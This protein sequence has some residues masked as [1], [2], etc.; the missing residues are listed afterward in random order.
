MSHEL[1]L[2]S[3]N[4]HSVVSSIVSQH[5]YRISS[6]TLPK[7]FAIDQSYQITAVSRQSDGTALIFTNQGIKKLPLELIPDNFTAGELKIQHIN[8]VYQLN[9]LQKIENATQFPNLEEFVKQAL[10]ELPAFK[11]LKNYLHQPFVTVELKPETKELF[12]K[13]YDS[14][15]QPSEIL[16]EILINIGAREK[17]QSEV[18]TLLTISSNQENIKEIIVSIEKHLS[19][20]TNQ[21]PSLNNLTKLIEIVRNTSNIKVAQIRDDL[22]QIIN[23]QKELLTQGQNKLTP[24]QNSLATEITNK[25]L[26]NPT[27]EA[28]KLSTFKLIE[29]A[30]GA[31][32]NSLAKISLNNNFE[33]VPK[34]TSDQ[35]EVLFK[36][37]ELLLINSSTISLSLNTDNLLKNLMPLISNLEE[38]EVPEQVRQLLKGL[39][40]KAEIPEAKNHEI[41]NK[42]AGT[43]LSKEISLDSVKTELLSSSMQAV[44]QLKQLNQLISGQELL[45]KLNPL[46]KASGEPIFLLFPNLMQNFMSSLE[47][48]YL[49]GHQNR[50]EN[51]QK[52]GTGSKQKKKFD[53]VQFRVSLPYFGGVGVDLQYNDQE[54]FMQISLEKVEITNFIKPHLECLKNILSQRANRSIFIRVQTQTTKTIA[55]EWLQ[56][57]LSSEV[58]I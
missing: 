43:S 51:Q 42:K 24:S 29:S 28:E 55:P 16:K 53:R 58:E 27:L 23:Q 37:L 11:A 3:I 6:T 22:T 32:L 38:N 20:L 50:A 34:L 26:K 19:K 46:I 31:N 4:P 21:N 7:D 54:L 13:I 8:G 18:K 36:K 49:S 15:K 41:I 47:I 39:N 12:N 9:Y 33:Q 30:L 40:P 5:P 14:S 56:D 48:T 44:S 57:L 17:L 1:L 35:L 52:K 25:E 10:K 2:N 45:D